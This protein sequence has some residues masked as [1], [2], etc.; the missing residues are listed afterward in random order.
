MEFSVLNVDFNSL[1]PDPLGSRRPLHTRILVF[2]MSLAF[3]SCSLQEIKSKYVDEARVMKYCF[4]SY[5]ALCKRAL[6]YRLIEQLFGGHLL[7]S[8]I[9]KMETCIGTK[10]L[11]QMPMCKNSHSTVAKHSHIKH[12]SALS[13]LS[14]HK[15]LT[16]WS[17]VVDEYYFCPR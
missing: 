8:S 3:F 12:L 7:S 11:N 13:R 4:V 10:K 6:I 15:L 5:V 16:L 14:P 1:I 2:F 17:F 9:A